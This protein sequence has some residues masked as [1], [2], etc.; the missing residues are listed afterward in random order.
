MGRAPASRGRGRPLATRALEE[1]AARGGHRRG[2]LDTSGYLTEAIALY[3]RCGYV[4]IAPCNQ[5][6][7][8]HH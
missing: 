4:E 1:A 2:V 6:E 5:N 8:A 3:H 7:Y